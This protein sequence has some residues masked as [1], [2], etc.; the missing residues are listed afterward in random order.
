MMRILIATG[1]A[2][3][4]EKAVQMGAQ[5][6]GNA[7]SKLTVLTVIKHE[8]EYSHAE[9]ILAHTVFHSGLNA[10][11][12]CT[13]IRVGNR[14][15]EIIR[16]SE[17]G[18][19]DLVI[20]GS[21][22]T[23]KLLTRLLGTTTEWVVS[24]APCPVLIAKGNPGPI[25]RILLCASGANSPSQHTL[26]TARLVSVLGRPC[27][28]TVLHVMS[29]ISAGPAAPH[30]WQ[31]YAGAAELIE[32]NEPEGELLQQDILALAH[33]QVQVQPR[34]RHGPIVEEILSEAQDGSYDLIVIGTH[35]TR[36]WHRFLLDDLAHQIVVQADRPVL[37]V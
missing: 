30:E 9:A 19:Y 31:L 6:A 32:K 27:E 26:F 28:I 4:S 15:K 13:R 22:P 8:A 16:E 34:V 23:H 17:E 12:I 11:N 35:Q 21:R 33:S 14:A 24:H 3:H 10:T 5:I 1:G 29:Q 2:A 25:R 18:S 37:V 7:G 20:V 36:D